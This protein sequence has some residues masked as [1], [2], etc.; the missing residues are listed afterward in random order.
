MLLEDVTTAFVFPLTSKA[1]V[2]PGNK[3]PVPTL[4]KVILVIVF[5]LPPGFSSS[6][7]LLQPKIVKANRK[8]K[9]FVENL[10][11]ILII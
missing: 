3:V 7:L 2:S 8:N 1:T 5:V 6:L 4:A 9:I 10:I 11:F